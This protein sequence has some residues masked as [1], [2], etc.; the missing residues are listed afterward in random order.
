M[1]YETHAAG[2]S[3]LLQDVQSQTDRRNLAIDSVGIRRLRLPAKIK[4]EQGVQETVATLELGVNLPGNQR[5]THMSRL[6]ELANNESAVID[7]KYVARLLN[8]ICERLAAE[9]A[10]LRIEFPYFVEKRAPISGVRSLMD[11]DCAF[12]GRKTS[13]ATTSELIVTAPVTSL[14]PCSK[15]ISDFGAHNQ[16]SSLTAVI[17]PKTESDITIE[18]TIRLLE[19]QASCGVYG[20]LK[21]SD[22]KYVTEHAYSHPKFVEDLVRDIA[23]ELKDDSRLVA[24]RVEA[25]NFESIHN[26][27]AFACIDSKTT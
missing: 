21:R 22:E 5:G 2:S 20:V 4:G 19:R 9:N 14:C 1:R 15:E 13:T 12:V 3:P 18:E 23:M 17:E 7:F 6:L 16:R 11:Y 27:S 26:H 24:F 8:M 10:T 25:E